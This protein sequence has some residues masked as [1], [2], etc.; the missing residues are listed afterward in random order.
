M[1]KGDILYLAVDTVRISQFVFR[2]YFMKSESGWNNN[3]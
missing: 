2:E 1:A 3:L